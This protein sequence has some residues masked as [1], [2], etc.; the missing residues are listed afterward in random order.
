MRERFSL[1]G[2]SARTAVKRRVS[3]TPS[4]ARVKFIPI[5][6]CM[7]PQPALKAPPPYV[8]AIVKLDEGPMLTAQLTDVDEQNVQI[9][10]PVEMVTPPHSQRRRRTRHIGLRLQ[11]SSI[12]WTNLISFFIGSKKILRS[13]AGYFCFKVLVVLVGCV[14]NAPYMS[15]Y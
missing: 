7:M 6:S 5:R 9:G 12:V 11:I 1:R 13:T 3:L 15:W 10:M 2:M 14:A 8:V 4:A